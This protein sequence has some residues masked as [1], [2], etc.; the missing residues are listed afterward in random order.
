MSRSK[1]RGQSGFTLVELLV[2]IAIIGVLIALLLPAVQQAREAARRMS[3][4]NNLKQIGLGLH[5][6][7]DTYKSFPIGSRHSSGSLADP[8]FGVS[9]WLG[10]LPFIEQGNLSD[11]LT[12]VGNHPGSLSSGGGGAYDGHSVNGPIVND[13]EITAMIC[14]SSPLQAVRSSGYSYTI[15]CPQYTGIS[16]AANDM[17]GFSANSATREWVGYQSGVASIGGMLTPLKAVKMRDATDGLSNTIIV[18]EQSDFVADTSGNKTATINNHQGFMCGINKTAFGFSER[19]FNTTTIMYPINGSTLALTGVKN[20][21][22][23]NNGI[24]SA[25]PGG[26]QVAVSDGSVRFLSENLNL[27]TLK[28]L[29]TRDDGEVLGS[30]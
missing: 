15:T 10:M 26:A 21:D 27:T 2:V 8:G 1:S 25:H 9:W 30:F 4:Q 22:G 24:F 14:P 16:G 23:L 13:R 19:T 20:N 3:C 18:G 28:L 29:A 11:Q 7:H 12:V 17:L 6:Y 5:N